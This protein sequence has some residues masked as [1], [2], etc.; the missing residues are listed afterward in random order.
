MDKEMMKKIIATLIRP[1]KEYDAIVWSPHK[2]KHIKKLE[3]I[4][5][6]TTLKK[7]EL[8]G[9]TYEERLEE[10]NLPTLEE[11]REKGD[12]ITV[13][14]LLNG[15]DKTDMNILSKEEAAYTR[16]HKKKLKKGR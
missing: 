14:K 8:E 2:K 7:L 16:G 10:M 15:M 1:K 11:K 6:I 5:R 3:R 9:R 12:L 13:Y 4:Q